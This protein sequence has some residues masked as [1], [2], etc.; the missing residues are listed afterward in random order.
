MRETVI[1]IQVFFGIIWSIGWLI[2]Y[3]LGYYKTSWT[4]DPQILQDLSIAYWRVSIINGVGIVSRYLVPILWLLS[5]IAT[6]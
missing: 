4:S 1:W 6:Y 3:H 2:S 5:G